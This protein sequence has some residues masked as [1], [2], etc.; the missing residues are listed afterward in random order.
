MD[1]TWSSSPLFFPFRMINYAGALSELIGGTSWFE[2]TTQSLM[3]SACEKTGLSD[4]GDPSFTQVL[5][6]VLRSSKNNRNL[7]LYEK[8]VFQSRLMIHLKNRLL[9]QR[10]LTRF[11]D[12]HTEKIIKPLFIIGLQRTGTTF[13]QKLLS[14]DPHNRILRDWESDPAPL[15]NLDRATRDR[16]IGRAH[17]KHRMFRFLAPHI[18]IIHPGSAR[19]PLECLPLLMNA[20]VFNTVPGFCELKEYV[21]WSRTQDKRESYDFYKRQIKLLQYLR[22]KSRWVLKAPM[23]LENLSF[24]ADAFPDARFIQIHRSPYESIPSGCSLYA[25]YL[26]MFRDISDLG[27]VGNAYVD[28]WG[29]ALE[30]GLEARKQISSDR[31]M[32]VDYTRLVADPVIT[33]KKIYSFFNMDVT[34]IFEQEMQRLLSRKRPERHRYSLEQFHITPSVIANRFEDYVVRF[35]IPI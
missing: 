7:S 22:P 23:H 29:H 11:P 17:L 6:R 31:M 12:I 15:P 10:E 19:G 30:K 33:V 28:M 8:I 24:L 9:I 25:T 34:P 20:F 18:S 26:N 14:K 5:D 16:R 2:T 1:Y 27:A 32:D 3:T 21:D 35:N 13:L 4:Y